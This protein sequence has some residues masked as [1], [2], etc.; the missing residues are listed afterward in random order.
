MNWNGCCL[1]QMKHAAHISHKI[2]TAVQDLSVLKISA[3]IYEEDHSLKVV[4]LFFPSNPPFKI[5]HR[6]A[7]FK[8]DSK[9]L[10]TP[11]LVSKAFA[12]DPQNHFSICVI[13][14]NYKDW[15][16][17]KTTRSSVFPLPSHTLGIKKNIFTNRRLISFLQWHK[18]IL[19]AECLNTLC[20]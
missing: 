11:R 9:P 17:N 19:K 6:Q 2:S 18:T 16:R 5:W 10:L 3:D 7:P 1:S 20:I 12:T 15:G 13:R 8:N 4:L 14:K